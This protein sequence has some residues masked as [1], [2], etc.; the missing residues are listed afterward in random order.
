[1][2]KPL[3]EKMRNIRNLIE[4]VSS[5]IFLIEID[6]ISQSS[7]VL[8]EDPEIR[9]DK[10]FKKIELKSHDFKVAIVQK[11]ILGVRLIF[12]GIDVNLHESFQGT[13]IYQVVN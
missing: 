7:L 12:L 5:G 13:L 2:K 6:N 1:L 11:L 9:L 3:D 8:D 4:S 10:D